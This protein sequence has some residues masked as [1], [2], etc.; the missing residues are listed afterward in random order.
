MGVVKGS[1]RLPWEH[2]IDAGFGQ[3]DLRIEA[4]LCI[5]PELDR[6]HSEVLL[7]IFAKE[8]GVGESE[9]VADFL[10]A[11]VG[12]FQ[13]ISDILLDMLRNPFVGC[14]ARILLAD[15]REVLGGDTELLGI[16][17]RCTVFHLNRMQQVE[18][19]LEMVVVCLRDG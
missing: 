9:S 1:L 3:N 11:V 4:F 5:V 18:E 16:P 14:L 15:G 17:L 12:L 10:D 7:H 6:C 19:P 13:I 2:S 8:R